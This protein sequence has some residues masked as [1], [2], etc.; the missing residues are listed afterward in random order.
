MTSRIVSEISYPSTAA[1]G[2]N[3]SNDDRTLTGENFTVGGDTTITNCDVLLATGTPQD[4]IN[5]TWDA[6]ATITGTQGS[7]IFG[8]M[9]QAPVMDVATVSSGATFPP[10]HII[11]IAYS[12]DS[13]DSGALGSGVEGLQVSGSIIPQTG[14]KVMIMMTGGGQQASGGGKIKFILKRGTTE[15]FSSHVMWGASAMNTFMCPLNYMDTTPG[16]NGSTSIIYSVYGVQNGSGNYY[17]NYDDS[18]TDSTS[19]MTL[20]EISG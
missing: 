12:S 14:N 7:L 9:M 4:S 16:G 5:L 15:I 8:S 3:Y 11:Q 1:I 20:M 18:V 10:G 19:T 6:D 17:A 13:T 2:G